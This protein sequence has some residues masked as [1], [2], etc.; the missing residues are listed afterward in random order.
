MKLRRK[1]IWLDRH[2]K[3]CCTV[4]LFR[5]RDAMRAHYARCCKWRGESLD[6]A[7]EILG[8]HMPWKKIKYSENKLKPDSG[9]VLLSLQDCGSSIVAHEFGHAVLHAFNIEK[10]KRY[11]IR[12]NSM[13][14]EEKLLH[15]LYYTMRQFNDWFWKVTTKDGRRFR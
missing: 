11:P 8:V 5:R 13:V 10:E 2:H 3:T 7:K 4:L 1:K 9:I 14:Q 15:M 6:D 12:I